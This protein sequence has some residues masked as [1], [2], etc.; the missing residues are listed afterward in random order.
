M[1]PI[2]KGV[3]QS[4][5][6]LVR[7]AA[8][9]LRRDWRAGELRLMAAAIV[10]AVASLATVGFLTDRVRRAIELQATELLAAD[11]VLQS[12][13]PVSPAIRSAAGAAGLVSTRTVGFRSMAVAGERME[14]VE[15]K[16]VEAG[17][18]IRGQL[19]SA[20]V[21]FGE[22]RPA[23]A[24]PARGTVWADP[25]LVQSLGVRPGDQ[26]GLG[27]TSFTLDRILT[28]EPDRGGDF[29]NIAPRLLMHLDD[30]PSTRLIA[31]GSRVSY[32]LLLGG[33][34]DAIGA[35]REGLERLDD[36]ALRVHGIRDA[37]PELRRALE[38][39]GQF[40]GL[41][42]IVSI[43]LCGLAIAMAARRYTTRQFDAC[44]VMRCLG[45]G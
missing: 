22:E 4:L 24:V 20:R 16:A 11:L 3:N 38:R 42:V 12:S 6:R 19:R 5:L 44:A 30:L 9:S 14:L 41:A 33:P 36:P 45:A 7:Q 40:L 13:E 25:R 10:V 15:L 43:A 18:P 27:Q 28:Y 34:G 23:A 2:R 29:F 26:I 39:A 1:S 35:F 32:R 21:L 8:A 17:Y 31:P 37:R